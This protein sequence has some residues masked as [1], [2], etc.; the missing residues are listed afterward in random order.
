MVNFPDG[1]V[2]LNKLA[3]KI[4][5]KVLEKEIDLRSESVQNR[6]TKREMKHETSE[7]Q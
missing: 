3:G 2:N 5:E 7:S 4:N 6:I 1:S